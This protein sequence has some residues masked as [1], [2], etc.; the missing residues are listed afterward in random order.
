MSNGLSD[1][2]VV[3]IKNILQ[4]Y[5]EIDK[6][7]LFGSRAKGNYK[8]AS[9]VDIAIM[10]KKADFSLAAKIKSH[11]E[12]DSYLPYFFDIISYNTIESDELKQHIRVY[13]KI[14]FEN[15]IPDEWVETTLGEVVNLIGGGTPKT[16][17]NEYWNG[18]IPWLSVVDFN[19]DNR[20]IS[21]TEKSITDLGLQKS[22]TKLLKVDDI[23]ISARGTVGAMAQLKREMAFNQSCYGIREIEDVSNSDFLFY[24]TKYSLKQINR[25]TYG[26]VFDTITTKT[27]NVININLPPL[28]EQ[29]AIAKILTAFDDK[30]ENLQ[31]QNKTLETTAQTIFKEWF[32]KYQVGDVLP[33]GWRVGKLSEI[34]NFLNGLALQKYPP[35]QGEESIPVIKIRELKQGITSNTDRANTTL[36]E[37]YIINN[38][39][40]LFS[41]S[42]SLEVVI[43]Q[44]GKGAL[45]QHLFKVTSADYP[46][47][48][49]Y[50]CILRHLREFKGVASDKATTM[51][52][53]NRKHLDL[54]EVMIPDETSLINQNKTFSPLI[55]RLENNHQQIQTLKRTRDTLLPKLMSGQLR[56]KDFKETEL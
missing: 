27:F 52:H 55:E 9:D 45:N 20:W 18:N 25:N 4:Q 28:Q 7:V 10:G 17:V 51:G 1:K 41:W 12:D 24:L 21:N 29:T 36:N 54:A 49:Y 16:T 44:N 32:G 14:I 48:F 43:W 38:G 31:A 22:S 33:E 40:V 47:W 56:V 37:K 39:D 2:Q 8:K 19:N 13:G 34:A 5:K 11:F 53:I 23:I 15:D 42:G 35:I 50:F 3:E 6:A 46:K 26:A 30:I